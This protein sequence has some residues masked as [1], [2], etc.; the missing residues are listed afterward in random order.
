MARRNSFSTSVTFMY[1][2][3]RHDDRFEQSSAKSFKVVTKLRIK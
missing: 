2:I 1:S 3:L